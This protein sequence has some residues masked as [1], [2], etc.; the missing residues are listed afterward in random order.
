M[1]APPPVPSVPDADRYVAY[2][3]ATA[4]TVFAVPFPVFG[5][6]ADVAVYLNGVN[7]GPSGSAWSFASASG[8]A[9]PEI[10]LPITD[11]QVVFGAGVTGTVEIIGD[12]RPRQ[13]ILDTAP[14]ITRR[15]YQQDLGQV[16]AA[17]R[18]A[19]TQFLE[20]LP[21][22]LPGRANTM[23]GFDSQGYLT[24]L[25]AVIPSDLVVSAAMA[26]VI[27][28]GTTAA[29]LGLMGFS[30]YFLTLI[31]AP[32][33]AAFATAIGF[34]T[35]GASLATAAN[36]AAALT[37]LGVS[38]FMQTVLPAANAAAAQT[39][40][41][42]TAFAQT[43]LSAANAAAA[44]TALG[45]SSLA[46]SVV[47]QPTPAAWQNLLGYGTGGVRQTVLGGPVSS[48]TGLPAFLPAT[49]T[50]LSLTSQLLTT[51][52]PLVVAAANGAAAGGAN[53]LIGIA[54]ANLTWGSLVANQTNYLYVT[55]AADGTLTPGSTILAPISQQG[56][57]PAVTNGQ[58]TFL[59][60]SMQAFLGNGTT[61]P[62][63]YV[64]VVGQAVT[65]PTSVIATVMSP[66][67]AATGSVSYLPL[68]GGT[69]T[70]PIVL[71]ADPA[72]SLQPATKQYVDNAAFTVSPLNEN[73]I[74][75]AGMTVD[76][77]NSGAS[78]TIVAAAALAYTVDRW[79]AASTAANVAGQRTASG[80]PAVSPSQY[81]YQFTGAA[82]V[83]QIQFGQRIE[84]GS[85]F[86]LAGGYATLSVNLADS[87]LPT[88]NWAAYYANSTDAFG[89]L[90]SPTKTLIASGTFSIGATP[91]RASV[92]FAVPSAATTGIEII[93]SVGAQTSGTWSISNVK[94]EIG[95]VAT[96]FNRQSLA[97]SM[98]DCQ[99]YYEQWLCASIN[100]TWLVGSMQS[101]TSV[102]GAWQY[103]VAKR[104]I[105]TL[106]NSAP[107][108]FRIVASSTPAL[109]TAV[110]LSASSTVAD[111]TLTTSGLTTGQSCLIQGASA[112]TLV[113]A[114]AEL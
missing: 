45:F 83:T 35:F 59:T 102:R 58:I 60:G 31:G 40:L 12:W 107:S 6:G 38:A 48:S 111:L 62:Q 112:G 104:A 19:W 51:T 21:L 37:T 103:A 5:S 81:A 10:A 89:T 108:G 8:V 94:L 85:S 86:D 54:T 53:D 109:A 67:R 14:A 15:E 39:A 2:A 26:P 97:K 76:Q 72:A 20:R 16:I 3:P 93:F 95:S 71:A 25:N 78:Q 106:A 7:Q 23:L 55:V 96:P 43:L 46:Q 90:A 92:V 28:A 61:A 17:Q 57:A 68:A 114:N 84:A 110:A 33:A 44:L 100:E 66:Y 18:E 1:A 64:V 70:G 34:S 80:G 69:M 49:G 74:V 98:A 87:L 9:V 56:G 75:N 36:A 13:G 105:P 91:T 47:T 29:A 77:R 113:S 79:W 99:R 52:T 11:G 41:G 27:A 63:A 50:T 30:S 4:T 73:R 42:I 22:S 101:A 24:S 88:C 32:N 82:G 65:G